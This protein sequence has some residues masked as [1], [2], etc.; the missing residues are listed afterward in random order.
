MRDAFEQ[1]QIIVRI[2]VEPRL[3]ERRARPALCR[4]PRVQPLYL[5]FL[6]ARDAGDAAGELATVLL[7]IGRDE[8]G[9]AELARDRRCDE[10]VGR[11]NYRA[12]VAAVAFDQR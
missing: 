5:A 1:R 2:A 11:G 6:E 4:E 3:A 9:H 8:M 12:H 10:T 7:G